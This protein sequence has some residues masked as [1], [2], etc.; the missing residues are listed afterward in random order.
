M[1]QLVL[2]RGNVYRKSIFNNILPKIEFG[3]FFL[4]ASLILFVAL[5]TISTL[6]FSTRQV[7]KGYALSKLEAT[8][9][10]LV[11]ESEVRAMEISTVRSLNHI[12][13]SSKVKSM[14]RPRSIAYMNTDTAIAK[15]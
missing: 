4:M 8:H 14:V 9:R 15:R 7:T 5:I 12:Q 2:N 1:S 3:P 13:Q 6:M 10:T 11:K